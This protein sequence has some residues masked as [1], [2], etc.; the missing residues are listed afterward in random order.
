MVQKQPMYPMRK[1]PFQG[2]VNEAA[3]ACE[4]VGGF[5]FDPPN[6]NF[7]SPFVGS[8]KFDFKR[9]LSGEN[10]IFSVLR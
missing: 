7:I 5:L 10:I 1:S 9:A 6:L 8:E 2:V 3:Q 4:D